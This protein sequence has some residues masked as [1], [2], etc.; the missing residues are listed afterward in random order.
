M[1]WLISKLEWA[2]SGG[3]EGGRVRILPSLSA[4]SERVLAAFGMRRA[5][6]VL[7]IRAVH[8]RHSSPVDTISGNQRDGQ[9]GMCRCA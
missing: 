2:K 8:T 5:T 7:T 9:D 3:R 6:D 1:R 4:V